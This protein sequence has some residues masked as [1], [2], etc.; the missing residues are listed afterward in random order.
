MPPLPLPK[1]WG[2]PHISGKA[3]GSVKVK[4]FTSKKAKLASKKTAVSPAKLEEAKHSECKFFP[5]FCDVPLTTFLDVILY[6]SR[7]LSHNA[8][9]RV[10]ISRSDN[11]E[12]MCHIVYTTMECQDV[13]MKPNLAFKLPNMMKS[14]SMTCL[15]TEEEWQDLIEAIEWVE[16]VEWVEAKDGDLVANIVISEKACHFCYSKSTILTLS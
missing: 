3:K 1:R 9:K 6:I 15:Q 11:F 12:T 10:A 14:L 7:V 8:R 4:T 13:P 2:H 5:T 16:A